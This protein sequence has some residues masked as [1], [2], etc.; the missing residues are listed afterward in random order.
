LY[1][2][3]METLFDGRMATGENAA[4]ISPTAS[5][6]LGTGF[7][8]TDDELDLPISQKLAESVLPPVQCHNPTKPRENAVVE[9]PKSLSRQSLV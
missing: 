2:E 1:V 5:S 7:P 3:E 9:W 4:G 8:D 6:Y